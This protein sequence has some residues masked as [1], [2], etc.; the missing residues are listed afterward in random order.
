MEKASTQVRMLVISN[1]RFLEGVTT[2]VPSREVCVSV[3]LTFK[4]S[5]RRSARSA[6]RPE[7]IFGTS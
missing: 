3:S 5:G 1:E 7:L 4:L 6:K 2:N